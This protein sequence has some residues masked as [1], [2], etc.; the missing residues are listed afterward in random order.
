ME[1]IKKELFYGEMDRNLKVT[2][3]EHI[4]VSLLKSKKTKSSKES[5]VL[6]MF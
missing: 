4:E 2:P 6:T 5:A 3:G 1:N